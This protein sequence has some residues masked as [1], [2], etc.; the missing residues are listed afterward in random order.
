LIRF[1]ARLLRP[2]AAK[3][4]AWTFLVVP[5]SASARLPTRS[6]TTV[7]GTINH[8]PFRATLAPDG[9]RSHWL[10]VTKAMREWARAKVGDLVSLEIMPAERE[11]EARV[12]PSLRKALAAAPKAR[13]VW[14][15]ISP[16]ARRDWI[17]WMTSAKQ[18]ETRERRVESACDML[19][20]GKRRVCCF[21]RSGIYSGGFCAPKAADSPS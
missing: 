1:K 18:A 6:A 4:V 10:K 2:V 21:D 5:R 14:S 16:T 9:R 12:P 11:R 19:A 20:S 17:D 7:T 8:S 3:S 13:A 15:D